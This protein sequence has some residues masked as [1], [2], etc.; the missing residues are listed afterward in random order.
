MCVF[1]KPKVPSAAPQV[2]AAPGNAESSRQADLEARRRK[3]A[4]AA[5]NILTTPVGLP[6]VTTQLGAPA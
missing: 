5:A 2:F 1:S 3:R 6:A 4:G